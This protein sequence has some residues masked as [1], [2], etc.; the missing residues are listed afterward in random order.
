MAAKISVEDSARET[1]VRRTSTS[2]RTR[3][4]G[5]CRNP[6]LSSSEPVVEERDEHA[7][8]RAREMGQARMTPG[9][10]YVADTLK[11]LFGALSLGE[12]IIRF[13][14]E[15]KVILNPKCSDTSML[16]GKR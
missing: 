2:A 14:E 10:S 5:V 1:Y 8:E 4:S 6:R 9:Y 15:L 3:R 12:N 11:D 13:N 7:R 16:K